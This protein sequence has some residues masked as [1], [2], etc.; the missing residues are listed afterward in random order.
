MKKIAVIGLYFCLFVC[1]AFVIQ[2]AF[3]GE[4]GLSI[5]GSYDNSFSADYDYIL[6]D[7]NSYGSSSSY[8]YIANNDNFDYSDSNYDFFSNIP[9]SLSLSMDNN[10]FYAPSNLDYLNNDNYDF[11]NL[12]NNYLSNIPDKLSLSMGDMGNNLYNAPFNDFDYYPPAQ[13]FATDVVSVGL[14]PAG[15]FGVRGN[16]HNSPPVGMPLDANDPLGSPINNDTLPTNPGM[17]NPADFPINTKALQ[18]IA[19]EGFMLPKNNVD[20]QSD[21]SINHDPLCG[22]MDYDTSMA[23]LSDINTAPGPTVGMPFDNNQQASASVD[24]MADNLISMPGASDL[25]IA[26]LPAADITSYPHGDCRSAQDIAAHPS[27]FLNTPDLYTKSAA[28]PVN[29]L[30]KNTPA[31]VPAYEQTVLETGNRALVR[32]PSDPI[33]Y[34]GID[35]TPANDPSMLSKIGS[36]IGKGLSYVWEGKKGPGNEGGGIAGVISGVVSVVPYVANASITGVAGDIKDGA[37]KVS[38]LWKDEPVEVPSVIQPREIVPPP[39]VEPGSTRKTTIPTIPESTFTKINNKAAEVVDYVGEASLVKVVGDIKE[40]VKWTTGKIAN[41][42]DYVV[43]KASSLWSQSEPQTPNPYAGSENYDMPVPQA[44]PFDYIPNTAVTEPNTTSTY[45]GENIDNMMRSHD[46]Y[47]DDNSGINI[48]AANP[49]IDRTTLGAQAPIHDALSPSIAQPNDT[50]D[51]IEAD[52]D[53]YPTLDIQSG[54]TD[55]YDFVTP[56]APS[57]N[58]PIGDLSNHPLRLDRLKSDSDTNPIKY[59]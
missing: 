31:T 30:S 34:T 6:N 18:R 22:G 57:Y 24:S 38:S 43:D 51:H 49:I 10:N 13:N 56:P 12:N 23:G 8:D 25:E 42:T 59:Y 45:N 50:N 47:L 28:A 16:I 39:F 19:A 14:E 41:G 27:N 46:P 40:G 33:G 20:N 7:N 4:D 3:A 37:Q 11:A 36:G 2:K 32:D 35:T 54:P 52:F 48:N 15:A 17:N 53:L 21:I 5:S 1:S 55:H 9:D 44:A 29:D 26:S 58:N